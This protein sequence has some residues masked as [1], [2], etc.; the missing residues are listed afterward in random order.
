LRR[1]VASLLL[2]PALSLPLSALADDDEER[3]I[4]PSTVDD[5]VK[6]KVSEPIEVEDIVITTQTDADRFVNAT[7][8]LALALGIGSLSLVIYTLARSSNGTEKD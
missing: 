3:V 2:L 5:Q 1:I 8:P 4:G 7:T 6:S